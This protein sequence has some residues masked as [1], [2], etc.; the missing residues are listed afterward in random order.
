[1]F[2]MSTKFEENRSTIRLLLCDFKLLV[3][4]CK[5]ENINKKNQR[6]LRANISQTAG[7]ISFKFGLEG[8]AYVEHK[9][10]KLCR[11]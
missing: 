11:N 1:M 3:A 2:Y 5:E 9:I 7:A 8:R 6:H 4:W 10:C